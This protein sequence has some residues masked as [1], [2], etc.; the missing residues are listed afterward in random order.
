VEDGA[1]EG[2]FGVAGGIDEDEEGDGELWSFVL[3]GVAD[4]NRS[5][6]SVAYKTTG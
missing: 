3:A 1:V 5:E 4:D 2:G 6:G